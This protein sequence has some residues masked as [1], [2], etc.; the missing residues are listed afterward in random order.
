MTP[1]ASAVAAPAVA[2]LSSRVPRR[3]VGAAIVAAT[4]AGFGLV[5][6]LAEQPDTPLR[7]LQPLVAL[8]AVLVGLLVRRRVPGL[9]WVSFITASLLATTV[10]IRAMAIVNAETHTLAEWLPPALAV[11]ATVIGTTAVAAL[12]ATRPERRLGD[13]V[14][15]LATVIGGW[16]AAACVLVVVLVASGMREDPGLT[17]AD[18]A[19]LPTTLHLHLVL[20]LVALGAAADVRLGLARADARLAESGAGQA[21]WRERLRATVDELTPG[22]AERHDR[23]VDAERRRLASDLHAV[24]LPSLRRAIA[25]AEAGSGPDVLARRLRAVD[26][27]LQRLLAERWPMV[28]ETFG[29]VEALEELAEAVEADAG[30]TP[31]VEIEVL[32]ADGRP[33]ASIERAAWRVAQLAVDNAVRHARARVIRIVVGVRASRLSLEV[34]DD[35]AWLDDAAIER[36]RTGGGRGLADAR[37]MATSIGGRLDLGRG[38]A[39]GLAVRLEWAASGS[40]SVLRDG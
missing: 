9:A 29:L 8:A 26:R 14:V 27:D 21:G 37:R 23:D 6:R 15:P 30:A 4:V 10:P 34:V 36:L 3:L 25:E 11:A 5:V 35:G 20:L 2:A 40:S 38:P 18:I 12:Y 16:L 19:T 22:V 7:L 39:G 32:E 13:W 24:V 17:W 33:P 1:A 28:L 31:S